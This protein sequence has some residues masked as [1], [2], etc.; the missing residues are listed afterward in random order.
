[1]KEHIITWRRSITDLATDCAYLLTPK[2]GLELAAELQR[3]HDNEK[4]RADKYL[5]QGE[6]E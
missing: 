4:L 5:G 1:M 2:Q 6:E 3:F